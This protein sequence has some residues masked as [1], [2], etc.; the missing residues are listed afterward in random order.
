MVSICLAMASSLSLPKR[1]A[2]KPGV[3]SVSVPADRIS[4]VCHPAAESGGFVFSPAGFTR[5]MAVLPDSFHWLSGTLFYPVA[6]NR[7]GCKDNKRSL[8]PI[9][10][11]TSSKRDRQ[12]IRH[13]QPGITDTPLLSAPDRGS[14]GVR[15]RRID[16]CFAGKGTIRQPEIV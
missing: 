7:Y 1:S 11:G 14:D 13:L 9:L 5:A 6:P 3:I 4:V 10:S 12:R 2:M 16:D 8:R 15:F